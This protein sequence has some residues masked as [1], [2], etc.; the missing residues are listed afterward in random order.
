MIM[1][2]ERKREHMILAHLQA[3]GITDDRV[4]SVMEKLRREI[5]VPSEYKN[6]AYDDNPLPIGLMQTISQP[7]I[8]AYMTQALNLKESDTVLEVGTGSGY[9]TAILA[10]LSKFVYT[11]ERHAKLAYNARENLNFLGIENYKSVIA[12][13]SNGLPE[14]APFDKIIVTA[15][16]KRIPEKLIAQ[17]K[18]NGIMVTPVGAEGSIQ[19]LLLIKKVGERYTKNNLCFVRFVP[20]IE[21]EIDE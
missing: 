12:D 2:F 5:F 8:V 20:L 9:Q 13:G 17:L 10:K 4:L 18:D 14:Y 3:R 1:D 7:Y 11:I 19:E 6:C 16:A 21:G 15:S